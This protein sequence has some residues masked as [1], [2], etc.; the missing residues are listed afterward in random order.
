MEGE[1]EWCAA[2]ARAEPSRLDEKSGKQETSHGPDSVMRIRTQK[3]ENATRM[4]APAVSYVTGGP[5]L[6]PKFSG[7]GLNLRGS[8]GQVD[9]LP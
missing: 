7:V 3:S 5:A 8:T 2:P 9:L 1:G 4:V 6:L